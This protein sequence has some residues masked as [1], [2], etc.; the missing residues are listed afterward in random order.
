MSTYLGINATA[1]WSGTGGGTFKEVTAVRVD[2]GGEPIYH[3]AGVDTFVTYQS[4]QKKLTTV[5]VVS[6]DPAVLLAIRGGS[7]TLSITIPP[8]GA[9]TVTTTITGAAML[10]DVTGGSAHASVD[11]SHTLTFTS[12]STDGSSEPITISQA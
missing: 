12:V 10:V 8:A 6:D 3:S 5:I 9:S 4:L 1:S 7:G 11:A 2:R